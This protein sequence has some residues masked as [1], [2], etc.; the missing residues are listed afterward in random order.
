[1][2]TISIL[3]CGWLGLPL[4]ENLLKDDYKIKGSTTSELKLTLL[5]SKNI[6]AYKI[7]LNPEVIADGAEKFFDCDILIINIPLLR[8]E[9]IVEY[10]FLQVES[11]VKQILNTS[12][13]KVIFIS[14]T[15]VY[16]NKNS[17]VDESSKT[18]PETLAGEA[19]VIAENY[20]LSQK[21]FDT[22]VIRFAGLIGG[23][24]NPAKFALSR[25]VIEFADTPL[26][27]IHLDDCIGIIKNVLEKNIR[28]EVING[29][30]EY[31][32]TR[33]EFYS[34]SAEKLSLPLPNFQDG[35]EPYKIVKSIK[36]KSLLNYQFKFLNS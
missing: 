35:K 5:Q 32:P 15:S 29:V 11:I 2:K 14:S 10:H 30:A 17:E 13:N 19:L 36:I 28:N 3:G 20:L 6:E 24:R 26:N 9:D 1:M 7:V 4:A 16:G 25:D 23:E 33:R 8:R 34:L 18:L 27:L 21:N 31:H 12:C 22:T